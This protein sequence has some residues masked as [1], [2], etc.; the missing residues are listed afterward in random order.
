MNT[1]RLPPPFFVVTV[2]TLEPLPSIRSSESAKVKLFPFPD[3]LA[4]MI[5]TPVAFV[6]VNVAVPDSFAVLL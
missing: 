4:L 6:I 3:C 2:S 5:L 1:P